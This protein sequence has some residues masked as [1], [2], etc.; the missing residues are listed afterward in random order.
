MEYS[1]LLKFALGEPVEIITYDDL[2]YVGILTGRR[3]AIRIALFYHGKNLMYG[4]ERGIGYKDI[5]EITSLV[6]G[7]LHIMVD[8]EE[9]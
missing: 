2:R 7:N 4:E 6:P 3:M 8:R 5:K 1:Q 9:D